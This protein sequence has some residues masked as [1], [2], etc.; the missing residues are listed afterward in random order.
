[1]CPDGNYNQCVSGVYTR[2]PVDTQP[3]NLEL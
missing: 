2:V 3:A 1:M